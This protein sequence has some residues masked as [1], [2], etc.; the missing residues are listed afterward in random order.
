MSKLGCDYDALSAIKPDIV[1]CS[2]SGF[3]QTGPWRQWPA[4]AHIVHAVSGLTYLEQAAD[5]EPRVA[6]LQ[7]ADVY[8]ATNAFGA[9]VAGL[10][11]RERTGRGAYLD[12]SMLESLVAS[13][14]I[15]F[16]SVLNGGA[17]YLGPRPGMVVHRIGDRYLAMQTVGAPDLWARMV[18]LMER[19]ELA[20]D[21]RFATPRAR[22][23]N[24]PA[25][26]A[27]IVAWLDRFKTVDDALAALGAARVPC[28]PVLSPSEV[29]EL[30]QLEARQAF[31][32]VEQPKRGTV[33]VTAPPFHV[34]RHPVAPAAGAPYRPG[35][36]TR[37]VLR[38]VLGYS[39]AQIDE[40]VAA[41]A[42]AAP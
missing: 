6:Y 26:R 18:R 37:A 31:P 11:R 41:K 10:F 30:P 20:S 29:V 33:R 7:A 13:E 38:D 4:F 1:Y 9:I 25:I 16:G 24:W 14:D 3:G 2:I 35:E 36:H 27:L 28:A 15:T 17:E 8:A 32:A 19:P 22:R 5:P 39:A 21:P 34:D 40:L 12:V 42:I 23:E